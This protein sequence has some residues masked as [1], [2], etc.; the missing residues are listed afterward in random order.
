M[1]K[2][3]GSLWER[4]DQHGNTYYSGKI[5]IDEMEYKINIQPHTKRDERDY[6]FKIYATTVKG[7]E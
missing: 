5:F 1:S 2:Q 7:V 4:K 3:I 6:S